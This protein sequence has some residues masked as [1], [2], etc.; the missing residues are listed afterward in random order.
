M[1]LEKFPNYHHAHDV[2][3]VAPSAIDEEGYRSRCLHAPFVVRGAAQHWDACQSWNVETLLGNLA[4]VDDLFHS[5]GSMELSSPLREYA[6]TPYGAERAKRRA[7]TTKALPAST[8]LQRLAAGEKATAYGI[9]L[10]TPGLQTLRHKTGDLSFL[11]SPWDAKGTYTN[12]LFIYR[13]GYTDWHFHLYDLAVAVQGMG[14]KQFLLLPPDKRTFDALWRVVKRQG[15]WEADFDRQPAAA[16]LRP[17]RVTLEPGDALHI[18]LFWWHAV[19]PVDQEI[20]FNFAFFLEP[21]RDALYDLRFPAARM[22]LR[23]AVALR[24]Q[25][26][27]IPRLCFEACRSFARHPLSPSYLTPR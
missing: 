13:G 9:G 15:V 23:L 7:E 16:Q 11:K 2:A 17:Y 5:P 25:R 3:E 4:G 27:K 8:F 14:R 12:S 24:S 21:P 1:H 6:G 18:P 10:R 26:S 22:N 19:E 20:G